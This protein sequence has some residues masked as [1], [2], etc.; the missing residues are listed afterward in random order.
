MQKSRCFDSCILDLTVLPKWN[1]TCSKLKIPQILSIKRCK[2][3][4]WIKHTIKNASKLYLLTY[5]LTPRSRVLPDKLTC[6]LLIKKIPTIY[7][8]VKFLTSFT[9]ARHLSLSWARSIQFLL[10]HLTSSRSILMLYFHLRLVFRMASFLQFSPLKL[11]MRLSSPLSLKC[12]MPRR[13]H[14]S[15][16]DHPSKWH[17]CSK[18]YIIFNF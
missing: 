5:L 3:L 15:K 11:C 13:A 2:Y 7:G 14:S 18:E 9:E 4:I 6:S 1:C 10:P 8:D 17:T 16:F 12:Y